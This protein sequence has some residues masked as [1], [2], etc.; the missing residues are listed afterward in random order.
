MYSYEPSR[1]SYQNYIPGMRPSRDAADRSRCESVTPIFDALCSE[2]R[3][4]FRTL[5]GDRA[6]EEDLGFKG[7]GSQQGQGGYYG[8]LTGHSPYSGHS[9]HHGSWDTYHT[10]GRQR[11]ALPALP[12]G[13]R[14]GR[15]RGF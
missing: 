1:T 12:P 2:Y 9:G 4:A 10:H 15:S 11:G 3:R 13:A 14:D 6:G 8:Q 5:P 7:F